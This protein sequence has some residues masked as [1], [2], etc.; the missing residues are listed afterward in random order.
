MTI[1]CVAKGK[2][3]SKGNAFVLPEPFLKPDSGR[4]LYG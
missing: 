2:L 1:G 3:L 4:I